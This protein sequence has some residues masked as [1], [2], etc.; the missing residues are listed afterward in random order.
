MQRQL[1]RHPEADLVDGQGAETTT[2]WE[3]EPL[4]GSGVDNGDTGCLLQLYF[5]LF[6]SSDWTGR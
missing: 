6:P 4:C 1:A 5:I 3:L 2:V